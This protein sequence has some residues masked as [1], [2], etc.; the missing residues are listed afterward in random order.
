MVPPK[1]EFL[2][3]ITKVAFARS[4]SLRLNTVSLAVPCATVPRRRAAARSGS[5]AAGA[6]FDVKFESDVARP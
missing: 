5:A 1:S 2:H 3:R 6:N 4:S